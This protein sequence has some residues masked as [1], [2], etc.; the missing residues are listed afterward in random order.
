MKGTY[1]LVIYLN[2]DSKISIG[3]LGS[4]QFKKGYYYYIGSAMANKASSTLLNRLKRHIKAPENKKNHWHIDYLLQDQNA[5]L[6]EIRLIPATWRFECIIAEEVLG[7]SDNYVENFGSSDCKC[8][9]H[10]L[11][12]E[13]YKKKN[14]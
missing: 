8:K 12:C 1:I 6:I 2:T 11:Y 10:L 7:Q 4:I 9:S 3:S 14:Y 13:N 5:Y